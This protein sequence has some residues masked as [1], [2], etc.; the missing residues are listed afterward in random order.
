MCEVFTRRIKYSDSDLPFK[1]MLG[2]SKHHFLTILIKFMKTDMILKHVLDLIS[3]IIY[4]NARV[5][6]CINGYQKLLDNTPSSISI[7]THECLLI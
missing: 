5:C 4:C 6:V 1:T 7:H 3:V 2:I